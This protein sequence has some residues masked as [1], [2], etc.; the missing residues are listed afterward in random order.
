[1]GAKTNRPN[2]EPPV[3]VDPEGG[4]IGTRGSKVAREVPPDAMS[5]KEFQRLSN[6]IADR[7]RDTDTSMT[8]ASRDRDRATPRDVSYVESSRLRGA[9]PAEGEFR[10]AMSS[11]QRKQRSA[12]KNQVI[13][14]APESQRKALRAMV[15]DDDAGQWRRINW[16]LHKNAG[17]VQALEDADRQTV[18]RLDR[19]VQSYERGSDRTH[20]VYVSVRMP[21][22]HPDV[23]TSSE[24]PSTLQP[25]AVVSF[26]Q[27][28]VGHHNLHEVP[29]HDDPRYVVLELVTS[30]GMYMGRSDSVEDTSHL[31]PRGIRARAVGADAATYAAGGSHGDRLVVQ[32]QEEP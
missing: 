12:L 24:L 1:M 16:H 20:K 28:T 7:M 27:F 25:G 19:L 10:P 9:L 30:R 18:Q 17:D 11:R 15:T 5:D 6:R 4:L 29:G 22:R 2:Y 14:S 23:T 32:L 3:V 13:N 21:D 31:L 8:R 26:D